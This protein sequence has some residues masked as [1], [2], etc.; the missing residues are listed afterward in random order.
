MIQRIREFLK[1]EA[2]E[3]ASLDINEVVQ[4]AIAFARAELLKGQITLRLELSGELPTVR[5]DRIQLQQVILNLIMNGAEAMASIQGSRELLVTSQA[6][7]AGGIL[8]SVRDSGIG[9]KPEDMNRMFDPFFTT[10]PTGMGMGLSVSRS[11]IEAH[12]GRIWA[13]TNGDP[14]LTV[15][16]SL[17]AES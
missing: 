6:S 11:I 1:K 14:G 17:P 8:V 13:A 4:E 10:K 12:G 9:I 2:R 16:F 15:Q 5:G 3:T 7:A